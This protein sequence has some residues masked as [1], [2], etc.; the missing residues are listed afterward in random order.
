MASL[1]TTVRDS[2]RLCAGSALR[3]PAARA[4][5]RRTMRV[6]SP[7]IVLFYY[8]RVFDIDVQPVYQLGIGREYF[9]RQ[10]LDLGRVY[11]FVPLKEALEAARAERG[12]KDRDICCI[13][14]D[15]GYR[16]N[17]DV[18]FP[19]LRDL[20]IPATVFV[21]AGL[22][23]TQEL[24]WFDQVKQA[25]EKAPGPLLR[26]PAA[27]GG[28]SLD[29]SSPRSRR[30]ALH[31]LL[32]RCK[33]LDDETRRAAVESIVAEMDQPLDRERDALLSWAEVRAMEA[34]G[35][36]FGSHTL[37][38]PILP[39]IEEPAVLR[40][41]LAGSLRILKEHAAH[42][43]PVLAY[44]NGDWSPRVVE[45]ARECGYE[46]AITNYVG[47]A[48]PLEDPMLVRRRA[49]GP[50]ASRLRGRHS[51]AALLFHTEGVMD[52]TRRKRR[53][54]TAARPPA[55]PAGRGARV[56]EATFDGKAEAYDHDRR[57]DPAFEG[58]AAEILRMLETPGGLLVEV[59]CG[60]GISSARLASRGWRVVATDI[61]M[62]MVRRAQA[63]AARSGVPILGFVQCDAQ[64]LPFRSGCA[65][66]VMSH[67][68][69]EYV[70][71]QR[72]AVAELARVASG[73]AQIVLAAPS[74]LAPAS[75]AGSVLAVLVR[76][77]RRTRGPRM[78]VHYLMPW[79]QD[80]LAREAGLARREGVAQT[81]ALLPPYLFPRPWLRWNNRVAGSLPRWWFFRWWGTEYIARY[82]KP[83]S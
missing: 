56:V 69:L 47:D 37:S 49:L 28:G 46:W 7:R 14:F 6:P 83:C 55:A 79:S 43:L 25:V 70:P 44:P 12:P 48:S 60:V 11:R 4:V 81:F 73:G 76:N 71:D 50:V 65:N 64:R 51:S 2:V 16:D 34:G 27:L 3:I 42:P 74:R 36:R 77:L 29:V 17:H 72:L 75:W 30:T 18:A 23:G 22:I 26:L 66:A 54:R 57:G 24:L 41:E 8:H 82:E 61:S 10:L 78:K 19:V 39:R 80:S 53:A 52:D 35:V 31:D 62:E 45:A 68:V 58:E 67:G 63:G 20:G 32:G 40:E 15:D 13:T 5:Y 38:H 33:D 9:R 21:V 59:G 1:R